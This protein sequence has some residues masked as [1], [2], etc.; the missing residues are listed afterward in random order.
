V[1]YYADHFAVYE[2]GDDYIVTTCPT[3]AEAKAI[4]KTMNREDRRGDGGLFFW[5]LVF[6]LRGFRPKYGVRP[7]RVFV[8]QLQP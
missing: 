3:R 7:E 2:I 1:A 8:V 6:I 5:L 4:A